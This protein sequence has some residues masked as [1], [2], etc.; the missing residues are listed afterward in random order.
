MNSQYRFEL[1]VC[2]NEGDISFEKLQNIWLPKALMSPYTVCKIL[3]F[4]MQITEEV[5]NPKDSNL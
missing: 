5:F 3:S 2:Y 1:S 4:Q